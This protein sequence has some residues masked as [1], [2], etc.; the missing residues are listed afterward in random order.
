MTY[1]SSHGGA[2]DGPGSGGGADPGGENVGAGSENI[3][4]SPKVR[5]GGADV[6]DVSSTDGADGWLGGGAEA[7]G[8]LVVVA[9][10]D[11]D[12]STGLDGLCDCVVGGLGE[13]G[14][15]RERQNSSVDADGAAG[16]VDRPVDSVQD[17]GESS[18]TVTTEDL[19]TDDSGTFG[20]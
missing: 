4:Q 3:D 16:V 17:A 18:T 9:S 15:E 10:S 13:G 14:A 1:R 2:G 8:V 5:K 20:L 7:G 11:G 6:V 12:E 19:Y